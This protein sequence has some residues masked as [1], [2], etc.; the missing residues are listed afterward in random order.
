MRLAALVGSDSEGY[1]RIVEQPGR[2][3]SYQYRLARA[4]YFVPDVERVVTARLVTR[5]FGWDQNASRAFA[6][7]LLAPADLL[8]QVDDSPTYE[9]IGNLA[10]QLNVSRWVIEH[11]LENHGIALIE[12]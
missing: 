9:S 1:P 6:E 2:P 5:G 7:E 10:Q 12:A 4:L 3:E 8:D 11:Q